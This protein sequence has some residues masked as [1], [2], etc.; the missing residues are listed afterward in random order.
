MRED[1]ILSLGGLVTRKTGFEQRRAIGFAVFKLSEAPAARR[2]VF[3]RVLDHE[4]NVDRVAGN[5]RLGRPKALL[6]SSDGT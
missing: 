2:R 6:F 4:L 1:K 3:F 5:K